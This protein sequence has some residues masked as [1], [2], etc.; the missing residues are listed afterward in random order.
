MASLAEDKAAMCFCAAP[1][2]VRTTPRRCTP[3]HAAAPPDTAGAPLSQSGG[4][5]CAIRC[6]LSLRTSCSR[7]RSAPASVPWSL[8][9]CGAVL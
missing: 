1:A 5:R 2:R 3:L 7:R 8:T 4:C 6:E 9:H